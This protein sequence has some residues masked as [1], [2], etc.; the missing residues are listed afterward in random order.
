MSDDPGLIG[1]LVDTIHRLGPFAFPLMGLSLATLPTGPVLARI[2]AQGR[3]V[4]P[5]AWLA[6]PCAVL[7]SGLLGTWEGAGQALE[8]VAHCGCSAES[9]IALH[10]AAAEVTMYGLMAGGAVSGLAAT[11]QAAWVAGVLWRGPA[12]PEVC[13]A[14]LRLSLLLALSL[15][16]LSW[17]LSWG[18]IA[19]AELYEAGLG[20]PPSEGPEA[21]L[22]RLREASVGAALS[23]CTLLLGLLVMRR[24]ARSLGEL[25]RRPLQLGAALVL[26]AVLGSGGLAWRRAALVHLTTIWGSW[27]PVST[28]S[29]RLPSWPKDVPMPELRYGDDAVCEWAGADWRCHSAF[30]EALGSVAMGGT[31]LAPARLPARALAQAGPEGAYN[32][33]LACATPPRP[34]SGFWEQV[35]PPGIAQ[36]TGVDLFRL[37]ESG[38]EVQPDWTV[39]DLVHAYLRARAQPP[40]APQALGDQP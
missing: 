34:P 24:S 26:L 17:S 32:A 8:L 33:V 2:A 13:R 9:S 3:L 39:E 14:A 11:W 28:L 25:G 30:V 31:W 22:R 18:G 40:G 7:I 5:A 20:M 36:C 16:L 12:L 10:H 35:F 4:S 19:A 37:E 27:G 6:M 29:Y 38:V 15:A 23:A 1:L 21:A